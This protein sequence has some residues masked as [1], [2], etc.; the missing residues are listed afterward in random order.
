MTLILKFDLYRVKMYQR[1]KYLG[2]RSFRLKASAVDRQTHTHTHTHTHTYTQQTECATR[3]TKVVCKTASIRPVRF[4]RNWGLCTSPDCLAT[5]LI[6]FLL[7]V[8]LSSLTTSLK[9][10]TSNGRRFTPRIIFSPVNRRSTAGKVQLDRHTTA[11][12]RC[13]SHAPA[14]SAAQTT[15]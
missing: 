15:K 9:T 6:L 2:Q 14:A 10:T 7:L 13:C 12:C 5:V 1:A 4:W 11:S 3:A 8:V